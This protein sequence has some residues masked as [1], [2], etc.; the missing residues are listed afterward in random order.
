LGA[1][2]GLDVYYH[3][4]VSEDQGAT[5]K[6]VKEL[7]HQ[8]SRYFTVK[9]FVYS[10]IRD[11]HAT[12]LNGYVL[13]RV[14]RTRIPFLAAISR[15]TILKK[16]YN[17]AAAFSPRLF[18]ASKRLS[19][20]KYC[21]FVDSYSGL[22]VSILGKLYGKTLLFRP[23]DC[24]MSFGTQIYKL[25]SRALGALVIAYAMVIESTI[26][27]VSDLLLVPS[28]RTMYLFRKFYGTKDKFILCHYGIP[29][30]TGNQSGESRLAT[31]NQLRIQPYNRVLV[32]L[33][34]GDWLPNQLAIEYI[35]NE[36]GPFLESNIPDSLIL[37]VGRRT[38]IYQSRIRSRNVRVVGEVPDISPYMVAADLGIAPMAAM[39]GNSSKVIDYLS[40]GLP[41]LATGEAAETVEPQTGLFTAEMKAFAS[42][43]LDIFKNV[44][45]EGMRD[46]VKEEA[47][48]HYSFDRIVK[49]V[50]DGLKALEEGELEGSQLFLG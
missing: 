34:V 47:L 39:G 36:L 50:A 4:D 17:V 5:S 9:L 40:H 48:S 31:R 21:L 27:R 24:L 41:T 8:L 45:L 3:E 6:F 19:N 46:K 49:D 12:N 28:R 26:S 32:F 43:V 33:G 23:N 42:S 30:E 1:E 29:N 7:S 44:N 25:R 35:L 10:D 11:L 22:T 37:I 14:P 13:Y 2:R 20:V 38:E 18:F 15:I 16:V